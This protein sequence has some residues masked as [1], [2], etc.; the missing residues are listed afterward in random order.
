ML[1]VRR[2]A[3]TVLEQKTS[4]DFAGSHNGSGNSWLL[5]TAGLSFVILCQLLGALLAL[6]L[7]PMISAVSIGTLL[8]VSAVR[9]RASKPKTPRS[10]PDHVET[11]KLERGPP[12]W[13]GL[14]GKV[15][16]SRTQKKVKTESLHRQCGSPFINRLVCC[17]KTL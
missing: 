15:A 11:S 14:R 13:R 3:I 17:G 4:E 10:L 2:A 16:G 1:L 5:I 9:G 7:R 8:M 6:L 12:F